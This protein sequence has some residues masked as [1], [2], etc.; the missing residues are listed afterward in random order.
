MARAWSWGCWFR[1]VRIRGLQVR[2]VRGNTVDPVD[3]RDVRTYRDS[4]VAPLLDLRRRLKVVGDVLG[5][6]VRS[7]FSLSR[8]LEL[9]AQWNCVLEIGPVRPI[10]AE[11]LVCLQ[12]G[13]LGWFH[14][15]LCALHRIHRVVVLRRDEAIRSWRI[16]FREDALVR[17]KR[18]LKPDVVHPVSFWQCDPGLTHGGSGVLA[19]PAPID[20]EFRKAWLPYF[21]SLWAKGSQLGGILCGG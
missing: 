15:V 7:G 14:E 4:S 19:D 10:S 12:G 8:S 1:V 16:W 9:T 18:W 6:M 17:L 21:L 2:K 3:G 5:E 13:G 20:E 11:D